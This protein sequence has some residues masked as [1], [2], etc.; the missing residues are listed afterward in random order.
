EL[1]CCAVPHPSPAAGQR[2]GL[3]PFSVCEAAAL[4]AAGERGTARLLAPKAVVQ[5][6]ITLAVA[7]TQRTLP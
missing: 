4:L 3:P 7:V 1:A 6:R 5:G 2:F